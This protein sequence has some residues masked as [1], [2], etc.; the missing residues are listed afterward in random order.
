MTLAYQSAESF[1][2]RSWV[3]KFTCTSPHGWVNPRAHLKQP[4][5]ELVEAVR[6]HLLPAVGGRGKSDLCLP[7]PVN[8]DG[9]VVVEATRSTGP[10]MVSR[11]PPRSAASRPRT[12]CG[13]SCSIS[14]G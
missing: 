9:R 5:Q 12:T 2:V 8:H 4:D 14:A 11:S 10:E 1:G 3:S 13:S 6:V 7:K